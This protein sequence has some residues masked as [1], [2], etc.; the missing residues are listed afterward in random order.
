VIGEVRVVA[1][2]RLRAGHATCGRNSTAFFP[3]LWPPLPRQVRLRAVHADSSFCL[4]SYW[5]SGRSCGWPASSSSSPN[6]PRRSGTRCAAGECGPR[7][8]CVAPTAQSWPTRPRVGRRPRR[9]IL[10]RHRVAARPDAGGNKLL[11]V[12]GDVCQ[13]LVT[14]LPAS[15]PPLA[16]W[17]YDNGRADCENAI[18]ER[19]QGFALAGAGG[20]HRSPQPRRPSLLLHSPTTSPC[21][22]SVLSAGR[23]RS[24]STRRAS[25]ASSRPESSPIPPAKPPSSSPRRPAN[26]TGGR[27]CVKISCPRFPAAMQSKIAPLLPREISFNCKLPSKV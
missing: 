16:V 5:T 2:L 6:G 7:P 27:A 9:L 11:E 15:E 13:A 19:Q 25:G 12:P 10:I 23:R 14:S 22:S 1:Q 3:D 20:C 17:R 4:P 21:S 26:A 18:K 8:G 24:R